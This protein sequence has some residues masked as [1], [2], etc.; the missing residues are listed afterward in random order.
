[1]STRGLPV[2]KA[3]PRQPEEWTQFA[4]CR[5][6][7]DPDLWFAEDSA[8]IERAQTFCRSQ[9]IVREECLRAAL[10]EE[11]VPGNH[12]FGVRG[13][14]TAAQRLKLRRRTRAIA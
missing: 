10:R 7:S 14:V 12:P 13:G 3:M 5:G 2:L 1:M 8:G 11:R 6:S 9:C 4:A